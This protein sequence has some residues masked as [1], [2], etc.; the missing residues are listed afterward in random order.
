MPSTAT[1]TKTETEM[2]PFAELVFDFDIYPRHQIDATNVR[3]IR[4][5]IEAGDVPPPIVVDRKSMRVIDGFHRARAV[6]ALQGDDASVPCVVKN[7]STVQQMVLE[8]IALNARHG[9]RLSSYDKARA[10]IIAEKHKISLELTAK[11]L[12]ISIPRLSSLRL[13]K[14]A[15]NT[16]GDEVVI[17]A[18]MR[19]LAGEKLTAPQQSA[20]GHL[21]GMRPLYHVNQL[22]TLLEHDVLDLNEERLR[23]R[24]SHLHS[25][26]LRF[27]G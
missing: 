7:Y 20:I 11:A 27:I 19:H 10:L 15:I 3:S 8:A 5:A 13:A 17:K 16:D 25:L 1:A 22:I 9:V 2:I 26:L 4:E 14:T 23:E 21:D 24:L 12:S 18:S 6:A